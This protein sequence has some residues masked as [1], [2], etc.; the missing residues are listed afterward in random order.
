MNQAIMNNGIYKKYL[1]F[2]IIFLGVLGFTKSSF[3]ANLIKSA[4]FLSANWVNDWGEFTEYLTDYT[5]VS[6]FPRPGASD[7]YSITTV[8]P[9]VN[10]AWL[11]STLGHN[12]LTNFQFWARFWFYCTSDFNYANHNFFRIQ[13]ATGGGTYGLE[14]GLQPTT[15]WIDWYEPPYYG[16]YLSFSPFTYDSWHKFD[17]S[18]GWYDNGTGWVKI[19][20]DKSTFTQAAATIW[21]TSWNGPGNVGFYHVRLPLYDKGWGL[22]GQ[23]WIDD[24]QIWDGM[25]TGGDTVSPTIQITAPTSGS[26][27]SGS[28][29][30]VS[31][32]ASDNVGVAG[33]QFKL[34]GV[35]LEAEDTTSPYSITW[36]T[37]QTSNG[38]HALTATARDAAANQTTSSGVTV[39][40]SNAS[41]TQIP[42][43]PTSLTATAMSSSQINLTWTASTDNV[44]VTGYRIYRNGTQITTSQTSNYSDTGLS[45]STTYTYTVSAYDAAG[46]VSV[47][48][49]SATATTQAP[50]DTTPPAAP[51]GVRVQ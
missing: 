43:T 18:V 30:T 12:G 9:S 45:P 14:I 46:N 51:S 15:F 5:R 24:V 33:V 4:D 7:N 40:V 38:S 31:A 26:T 32:T 42:T 47:Q 39:N 44:G 8:A 23:W 10:T 41:D 16:D 13:P 35:N 1:I 6:N 36:N 22:T 50:A 34:D 21:H 19:W 27:V 20:V 28:S 11:A 3:A 29:V 17:I 37:T 25:P 48:S 2:A 49:T